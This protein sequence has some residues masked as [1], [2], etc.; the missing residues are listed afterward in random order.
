MK[1]GT[2]FNRRP[3]Q[4]WELVIMRYFY[5]NH[6]SQLLGRVLNRSHKQI[7]NAANRFGIKKDKEFVRELTRRAWQDGR[8]SKEKCFKPGQVPANKGQKMPAH[9]YERA[10]RTMF[11][12]GNEPHNTKH[13]GAITV[14]GMNKSTPEPYYYIRLAKAKWELL[15]RH[16]WMQAHGPIKRGYVIAFKDGNWQ[17]CKLENLECITMAENMKRNSVQNMPPELLEI[18]RMRASLSRTI[19]KLS[20]SKNHQQNGKEQ[21]V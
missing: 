6:T 10:A 16:I 12:P 3:W 13:D 8:C 14:R 7:Y 17:N 5:P 15:H 19:N 9:V 1:K 18:T 21:N 2:K 20:N 11:K 4:E